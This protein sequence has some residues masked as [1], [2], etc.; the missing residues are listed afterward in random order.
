MSESGVEAARVGLR[1]VPS[2]QSP[3][4]T[5]TYTRYIQDDDSSIAT[6]VVLRESLTR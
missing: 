4:P 5:H 6:S 3:P 2:D 1:S